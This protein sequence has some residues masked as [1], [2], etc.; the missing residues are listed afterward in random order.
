MLSTSQQSQ[1]DGF[2]YHRLPG[3]DNNDTVLF[4]VEARAVL[5]EDSTRRSPVLV[6]A[7]PLENEARGR[8]KKYV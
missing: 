6:S 8:R 1:N 7:V 5:E 4:T 3:A 2:N